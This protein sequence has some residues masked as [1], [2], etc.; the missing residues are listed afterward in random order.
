MKEIKVID[1]NAIYINFKGEK[2][3]LSW[4]ID[5]NGNYVAYCQSYNWLEAC[6]TEEGDDWR[7]EAFCCLPMN[8]QR[9][10]NFVTFN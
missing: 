10:F 4:C 2:Y 9:A 1:E 6:F 8:I 7:E 5:H 3:F